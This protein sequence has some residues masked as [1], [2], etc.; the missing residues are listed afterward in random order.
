MIIHY[1]AEKA[2]ING[3]ESHPSIERAVPA[4]HPVGAQVKWTAWSVPMVATNV[5]E[6]AALHMDRDSIISLLLH[7][8]FDE[9]H[10]NESV[11]MIGK[12]QQEQVFASGIDAETVEE[13][14]KRLTTGRSALLLINPD[15]CTGV[16]QHLQKDA[17]FLLQ[18][19]FTWDEELMVALVGGN[20][21][22]QL[23]EIHYKAISE[24]KAMQQAAPHSW[25]K[26]WMGDTPQL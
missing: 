15:D 9:T 10:G 6:T 13:V 18:K 1:G 11:E 3:I 14:R 21:A 12:I 22:E 5:S 24:V 17:D 4:V 8:A 2:R 23:A 26:R 25:L 7:Q 16:I 20:V 19:S